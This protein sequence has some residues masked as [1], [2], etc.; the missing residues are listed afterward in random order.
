M[1]IEA[2]SNR[3]QVPSSFTVPEEALDPLT[4][5]PMTE[6][7]CLLKCSHVVN[8][9]T[10]LKIMRTTSVCPFDGK[11]VEGYAPYY[12]MRNLAKN[13]TE[14][15]EALHMFKLGK[16]AMYRGETGKAKVWFSEALQIF[17]AYERAAAHLEFCTTAAQKMSQGIRPRLTDV[18]AAIVPPNPRLGFFSTAQE[19][20]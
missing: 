13:I 10:A 16:E 14:P 4:G 8:E 19:S 20:V 11:E 12:R 18:E 6:A 7:V 3:A 17:P 5:K 1:S 15:V 2:I 9:D